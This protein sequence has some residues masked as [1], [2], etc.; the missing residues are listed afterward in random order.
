MERCDL[1]PLLS[2]ER[3]PLSEGA[4]ADLLR[5]RFSYYTDDLAVLT[6]DRAFIYEPRGNYDVLDVIEVA[7]A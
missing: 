3:R 2:G 5:K 7:N 4:R 1:V 6:W